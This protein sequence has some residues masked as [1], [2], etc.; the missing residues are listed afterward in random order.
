MIRKSGVGLFL[1]FS[2]LIFSEKAI[3][4][5]EIPCMPPKIIRLIPNSGKAGDIIH[6]KGRRFGLNT[7]K[8]TFN[9]VPAEVLTWR[10][11]TIYLKAP[12]KAKSGPV[13]VYNG[14][15]KSNEIPFTYEGLPPEK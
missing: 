5:D 11:E 3:A 6:I 7:G 15:D 10:M 1:L 9:G 2:F 8:V 12:D 13:I 14:C 4:A